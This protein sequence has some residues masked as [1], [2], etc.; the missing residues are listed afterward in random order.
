MADI[1]ALRTA[2][3]RMGVS[4]NV[5]QE[6]TDTQ[7][8]N[9]LDELKILTDTEIETLCKAIRRPGGTMPNPAVAAA[10]GVAAAQLAG[11]PLEIQNT[12]HVISARAENNLKLAAYFL[13]FKERTSRTVTAADVVLDDVRALK[14]HKLWEET[15]EDVDDKPE[16]NEKDWP[17]TI[18]AMEEYFRGCLGTSSK[19]P[20][21]YVI[22]KEEAPSADPP[23]P[24]WTSK[25]EELIGRAP[26][27]AGANYVP[28][29]LA[30][31]V[32]VWELLSGL[33][34]N[35]ACWTY[36]KPF[37]RARDGRGAFLALRNHFLGPNNVDNM[38]TTAE[39]KL[40]NATYTSEKRRWNFEKFVTLH[41]DQHIILEGLVEHG[42]AGID[43]RSKVRYLLEGI[44][45]SE[46]DVVKSH[47][48]A[49]A[50]LRTDF[51]ACV[52]LFM[53][54]INQCKADKSAKSATIAAIERAKGGHEAGNVKPDMTV[55]DR[56]YKVNEYKQLSKAKRLGLKLLREKRGGGKSNTKIPVKANK[57]VKF[58]PSAKDLRAIKALI[59]SIQLDDE[60][61]DKMEVEEQQETPVEQQEVTNT[62]LNR[63]N[64][65]LKRPGKK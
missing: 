27:R 7:G 59:S 11:I 29:Y 42:Y 30:D 20:L 62:Y 15:H 25:A 23:A 17:R 8:I 10:G 19:I 60:E 58:A 18:E 22:R 16:I 28:N 37:M 55:E 5:A 1:V 57:K 4:N 44:K 38:A 36:C 31:N 6:I 45:T 64:N 56:Y 41:K 33:T 3:T 24:G 65:A 48:L 61:E 49:T 43:E 51:D 14:T 12:G 40:S 35:H 26:I 63:N 54:F 53:D 47:I 46:L 9:T 32:K 50:A 52:T 39:K 13:R 2:L 34:R 21:A